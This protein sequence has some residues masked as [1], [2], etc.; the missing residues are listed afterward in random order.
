MAVAGS[1]CEKCYVLKGFYRQKRVK[2]AQQ[3][4][5][6]RFDGPGWV[7]AMTRLVFWQMLETGLPFFRWFDSGDL[8]SVHMLRQIA[9]V[10]GQTPVVR[11][12]LPTRE[13]G[14]VREYLRE[15]S[16]PDNLVVRIS[17]PMVDGPAPRSLGLPTSTVHG[18]EEGPGFN[19]PARTSSPP[20]CGDCRACWDWRVGNVSY[21]LH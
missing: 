2:E 21:P 14:I 16:L 7:V 1:T 6:D 9:E 4:R 8:Q 11:H 12:W 20:N 10:A 3:R 13:Y 17:A 19:C 5:L 18:G 15:N